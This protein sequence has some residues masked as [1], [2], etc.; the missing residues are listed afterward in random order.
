MS[1]FLVSSSCTF[2]EESVELNTKCLV[3]IDWA[4]ARFSADTSSVGRRASLMDWPHKP[5]KWQ[6]LAARLKEPRPETGDRKALWIP[7]DP[8]PILAQA[9]LKP[10]ALDNLPFSVSFENVIGGWPWMRIGTRQVD[11]LH[12]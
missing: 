7:K 10:T 2:I 8:A 1:S 11:F 9:A 12:V 6:G 5:H 4:V 3:R